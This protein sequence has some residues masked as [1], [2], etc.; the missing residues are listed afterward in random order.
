M[1]D[2]LLFGLFEKI[3]G[4]FSVSGCSKHNYLEE[5][6]RI[7]CYNSSFRN[8]AIYIKDSEYTMTI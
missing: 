3:P 5:G 2:I 4:F 8:F 7:G 6:R 1:V